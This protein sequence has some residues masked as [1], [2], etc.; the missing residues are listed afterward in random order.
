MRRGPH[1]RPP[2]HHVERGRLSLVMP[3]VS[4]VTLVVSSVIPACAGIYPAAGFRR[5]SG[6][7]ASQVDGHSM[8]C[9]DGLACTYPSQAPQGTVYPLHGIGTRRRSRFL[10]YWSLYL[11]R[12][13]SISASL[14]LSGW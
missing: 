11:Q 12:V 2:L 3:V 7:P 14:A 4:P 6:P 5:P 9:P 13:D 10:V 8:L 1:P